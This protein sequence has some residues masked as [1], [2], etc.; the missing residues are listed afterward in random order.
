[1]KILLTYDDGETK[2]I[3]TDSFYLLTLD[4]NPSENQITKAVTHRPD[5]FHRIHGDLRELT[6]ELKQK[7]EEGYANASTTS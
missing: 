7:M 3:E 1:M 2:E 5:Y 6:K 4:F